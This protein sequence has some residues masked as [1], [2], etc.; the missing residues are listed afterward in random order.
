MVED[1]ESAVKEVKLAAKAKFDETVELVSRNFDAFAVFALPSRCSH[2][3]VTS[4][5]D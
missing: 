4:T 2:R 3:L 1:V 5:G